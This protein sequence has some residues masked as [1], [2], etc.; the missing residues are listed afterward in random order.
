MVPLV[1]VVEAEE[2]LVVEEETEAAV[3]VVVVSVEGV[4]V[5][6]VTGVSPVFLYVFELDSIRGNKRFQMVVRT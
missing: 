5:A 6:E 2:A 3:E 4:E 1:V